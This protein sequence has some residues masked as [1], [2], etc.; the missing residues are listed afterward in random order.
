MSENKLLTE[1]KELAKKIVLLCRELKMRSI[2]S[3][4]REQLLRSGTS[5]GANI[6]EAQYAQGTK[7]FISKFEIALKECNESEYWLELLYETNG[8]TSEEFKYFQKQC[9]DLRRMLVASV[10]TLKNK[11]KSDSD[12]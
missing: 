9:V 1:S 7:D 3:P 10:T 11:Q 4:I 12:T 8:I 6:H 5:V 2:E